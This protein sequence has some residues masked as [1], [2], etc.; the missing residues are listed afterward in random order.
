MDHHL[1]CIVFVI[2]HWNRESRCKELLLIAVVI[3]V[4][5]EVFSEDQHQVCASDVDLA[6]LPLKVRCKSV[7][8][9]P[10]LLLRFYQPVHSRQRPDDMKD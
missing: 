6:S 1:H 3:V 9:L 2:V 4:F 7:V 5:L 8:A 10:S